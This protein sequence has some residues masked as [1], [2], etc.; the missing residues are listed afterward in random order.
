MA[1]VWGYLG[2]TKRRESKISNRQRQTHGAQGRTDTDRHM[3]Y[4]DSPHTETRAD[5]HR[6]SQT[7]TDT[8][9]ARLKRAM[10]LMISMSGG[11]V[12]LP[13]YSTC[14]CGVFSWFN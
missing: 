6:H 3:V 14:I 1:G 9:R 4:G 10:R 8:C 5:T 2:L 12:L 13:K 11:S 7:Q